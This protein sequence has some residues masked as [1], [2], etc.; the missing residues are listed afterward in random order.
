VLAARN[1]LSHNTLR[2]CRKT[3]TFAVSCRHEQEQ[4]RCVAE[5]T[6]MIDE[7]SGFMVDSDDI[8][9][10]VR[11]SYSVEEVF[12]HEDIWDYAVD[13]F[14]KLEKKKVEAVELKAAES[15]QKMFA[16]WRS[17]IE[18]LRDLHDVVDS[19]LLVAMDKDDEMALN[20]AMNKAQ[21]ELGYFNDN[22]IT[23]RK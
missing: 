4:R 8:V 19:L 7:N 6:V 13:H 22:H 2:K 23:E 15:W 20:L 16:R 10:I 5:E 17:A 11:K 3:E 14:D 12:S 21:K 18:A 9:D 1:Q